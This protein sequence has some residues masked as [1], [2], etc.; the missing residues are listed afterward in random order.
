MTAKRVKQ[1][2]WSCAFF[3]TLGVL[4][5]WLVSSCID[6]DFDEM[7]NIPTVEYTDDKPHKRNI[8]RSDIGYHFA[9]QRGMNHVRIQV[10][11]DVKVLMLDTNFKEVDYYWFRRFNNWFADM[12][13]DNGIMPAG[14]DQNMDCDNFAMLYKSLASVASYKSKHAD[15]PAV[16]VMIVTQVNQFGGIPATS[17]LHMVNLIMTSRGWYVFEPQTGEHVLLEQYPNQSHVQLII[18]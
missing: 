9:N 3:V 18:F 12:K 13:H 17:G 4:V 14:G 7:K 5:L 6:T 1:I 10:P 15:E 2:C 16:A 11:R 8:T